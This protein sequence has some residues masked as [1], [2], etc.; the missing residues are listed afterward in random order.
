MYRQYSYNEDTKIFG[1]NARLPKIKLKFADIPYGR[2]L[3]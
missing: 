3:W 2:K 1:M